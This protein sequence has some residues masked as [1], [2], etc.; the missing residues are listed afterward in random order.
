MNDMKCSKCGKSIPASADEQNASICRECAFKT[1]ELPV[2]A[3]EKQ[4]GDYIIKNH[5]GI[6]GMG[7]VFLAEQKSLKRMVALKILQP[8]LAGNSEYLERFFNEVRMLAQV[9][10][11]NVVKAIEAGMDGSTC[12]F[13]MMY[14]PGKDLKRYLDEG[15]VFREH[16]ALEIITQVALAL[17]SVWKTHKLI[18]RDIKPANIMLAPE[19]EV[20][21]MDLGISKSLEKK[22]EITVAGMMIGSPTYMAPEQA[23]AQRD[24]DFRA[25]MYSLGASYYHMITGIPPYDADTSIGIISMH[26]SDPIPDPRKT[27]PSIS[28]SSSALIKKMMAKDRNDRFQN[29]DD[30]IEEITRITESLENNQTSTDGTTPASK[31]KS[32]IR[33]SVKSMGWQRITALLVLLFLFLLAFS[34]VVRKSINDTHRNNTARIYASAIQILENADSEQRKKALAILEQIK[35]SPYPGLSEKA[36]KSIAEFKKKTAEAKE[37]AALSKKM[38]ALDMLKKKSYEL[39]QD[40]KFKRAIELWNSYMKTGEFRNESSFREEASRSLEYLKR[41]QQEKLN[42]LLDE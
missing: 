30:A 21:L 13:S 27:N 37:K 12:Y 11:P 14:I 26:L 28:A 25:D 36:D 38:E 41:K 17:D 7:E 3:P 31:Y 29:W 33:S 4:I 23:R 16:D 42:G 39:E 34:A 20:K 5:L 6:G 1:V 22:D 32:V 19:G 35:K 15:K 2:Y 10:H 18:H 40:A 8:G 9:E 24:L